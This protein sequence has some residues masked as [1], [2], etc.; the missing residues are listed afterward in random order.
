MQKSKKPTHSSFVRLILVPCLI[1]AQPVLLHAKAKKQEG[2]R[3]PAVVKNP[4]DPILGCM[5]ANEVATRRLSNPKWAVRGSLGFAN[6]GLLVQTVE[7]TSQTGVIYKN[8]F[9]WILTRGG[10]A[11]VNVTGVRRNSESFLNQTLKIPLR[12]K[13]VREGVTEE[14]AEVV[15]AYTPGYDPK[16]PSNEDEKQG[17]QLW[18]LDG[19]PDADLFPGLGREESFESRKK[20]D[21]GLGV[22]LMGNDPDTRKV[23][24]EELRKRFGEF[25]IQSEEEKLAF[26]PQ[27]PEIQTRSDKISKELDALSDELNSNHDLLTGET[28]LD[29]NRAEFEKLRQEINKKQEKLWDDQ[30]KLR[31]DQK[32]VVS[33]LLKTQTLKDFIRGLKGCK[34][35]LE[36]D[37]WNEDEEFQP[38]YRSV[39]A[40]LDRLKALQL[41]AR[42]GQTP[43]GQKSGTGSATGAGQAQ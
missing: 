24:M 2:G 14:M 6:A 35:A 21:R 26:A 7:F 39:V 23:I 19:G 22:T 42:S 29:A 34:A 38:F 28:V 41:R 40:E 20:S 27:H 9:A 10:A 4:M 13:I 43:S 25:S 16:P 15:V 31:D 30:A 5:S 32:K 17:S 36:K 8:D 18:G 12:K 37:H 11:K 33:D 1:L 3:S